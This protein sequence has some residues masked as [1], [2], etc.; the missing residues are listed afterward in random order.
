MGILL[1]LSLSL[2]PALGQGASAEHS[3]GEWRTSGSKEGTATRVQVPQNP[4][5][6]KNWGLSHVDTQPGGPILLYLSCT[7]F[8]MCLG[9]I[10]NN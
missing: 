9:N 8:L 4:A 5:G 1:S 7:K 2:W 6:A 3:A 10:I